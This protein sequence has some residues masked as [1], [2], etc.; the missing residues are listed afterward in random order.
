MT[1]EAEKNAVRTA[2]KTIPGVKQVYTA[3]PKTFDATPCILIQLAGELPADFR[4]DSEY[5]TELEWYVRVFA[6]KEADMGPICA[7][8]RPTMEAIGY[9]RT[10]AADVGGED[11]H[12]T[13]YRF[14]KTG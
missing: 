7:V 2:L 5:L 4:D 14:V 3:W 9:R 6:K 1:M 11:I 13:L 10:F 12:Q 8:L